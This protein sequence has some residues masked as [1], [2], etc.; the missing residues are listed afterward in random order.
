MLS[1]LLIEYACGGGYDVYDLDMIELS[2]T[3][4]CWNPLFFG[5]LSLSFFF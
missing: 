4:A 2:V 1:T 5:N 3:F